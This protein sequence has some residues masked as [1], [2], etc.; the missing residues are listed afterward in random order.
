MVASLVGGANFGTAFETNLWNIS[1]ISDPTSM[2]VESSY[3][4]VKLFHQN[5]PDTAGR[6]NPTVVNGSCSDCS[7]I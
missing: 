5:K 3:D 2:T 6:Q 7:R 4:L 1:V